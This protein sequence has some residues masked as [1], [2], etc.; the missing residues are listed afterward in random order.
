[1]FLGK[2]GDERVKERICKKAKM[3][4]KAIKVKGLTGMLVNK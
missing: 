2:G 3:A 1:M 4:K